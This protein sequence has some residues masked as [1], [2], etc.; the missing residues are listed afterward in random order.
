MAAN[1]IIN[2]ILII[3]M[4][5][6]AGSFPCYGYEDKLTHPAL[7]LKAIE[8]SNLKM[9]LMQNY[10]NQFQDGFESFVNG[11]RIRTWLTSGSTAEDTP[12]CRPSN[13]FHNP[14]KSWDRAGISSIL[15]PICPSW[16]ITSY[17]TRHS[18]LTWATGYAAYKGTF[19][20]KS[21]GLTF[22]FLLAIVALCLAPS[23]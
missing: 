15:W 17:S 23:A 4:F 6:L 22:A 16:D 12:F 20:V 8:S 14:L 9:Y 7:T 19:R 13:H 21:C 18:A 3:A 10:G 5:T 1:K 11:Q 2:L